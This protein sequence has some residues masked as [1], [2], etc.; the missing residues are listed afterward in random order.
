[1]SGQL[2]IGITADTAF[3]GDRGVV[4][5]TDMASVKGSLETKAEKDDLGTIETAI[6]KS[7]TTETSERKAADTAEA[8]ERKAA[9]TK[10]RGQIDA[11]DKFAVMTEDEYDALETKDENTYYMLTED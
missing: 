8:T 5:E 4:L 3:A 9:D 6:N 2:A 1:M 10:L 11:L 7:I